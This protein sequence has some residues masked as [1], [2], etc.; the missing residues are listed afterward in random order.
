[1]GNSGKR[2]MLPFYGLPKCITERMRRQVVNVKRQNI[3][4]SQTQ[5]PYK[6]SKKKGCLGIYIKYIYFSREL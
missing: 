5:E 3:Y 4:K 1:M 6:F 2:V